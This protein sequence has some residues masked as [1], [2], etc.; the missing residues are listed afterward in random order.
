V[1]VFIDSGCLAYAT[2]SS[3]W[4]RKAGLPCF[5]IPPRYLRVIDGTSESPSI[6]KVAY[7]DALIG[8]HYQERIFA[9]VVPNQGYDIMLGLPWFQDQDV[10]KSP[11]ENRIHIRTSGTRVWN[12]ESENRIL[13]PTSGPG[14]SKPIP[15]SAVSFAWLSRQPDCEVFSASMADIEAMLKPKVKGDPKELLPEWAREYL[16]VFDRILAAKLP[17]HRHDIDHEINLVT[18][19]KGDEVQPPWGPL[20]SMTKDEL[21]VLRKTL[22]ELLDKGFIRVSQSPAAS[23]ILFAKKPGGGLRFCVD[24][25]GLNAVT[26][27][28]R[29]PLPLIKETL[30]ALTRA[31]W[32]TK[33]DIISAF[34][35]VRMK[36]GHEWKTAM[37]TRYGLFEWLVCPFGLTNAPSTFQ[38]FINW[39]LREYLDDF[40]TAYVDDLLIFSSGSRQDHRN[41]VKAVLQKLLDAGLHVDIDKCA[42]ETQEVKYLGFIVEAG[43]GIRMDPEKIRA[44]MDWKYPTSVKGIRS[45]L[46]FANFYRDFIAGFSHIA[47]PLTALTG[48]KAP[49]PF[50]LPEEAKAAFDLLKMKMAEEPV[51]A[52]YNPQLETVL[53]PDS[54][55]FATGGAL[56]QRHPEGLK[57]VA[58]YSKKLNSAEI[59]YPIH[60]KELLAIIRCLEEWNPEL[61]GL[62]QPLT[63]LTDH[64]NLEYFQKK[65]RLTERQVRW[66]DILSQHRYNLKYRPGKEAIVPDALSRRDQ[67]TP[68]RL[69]PRLSSRELQ[70]LPDQI[71][72]FA[73]YIDSSLPLEVSA[74]QI[75][76]SSLPKSSELPT[77][78]DLGLSDQLA[79]LWNQGIQHE[80]A[81]DN[82]TDQQYLRAYQS[83]RTE[84]KKFPNILGLKISM[85]EASLNNQKALCFRSRLWVPNYEPLR[86][87]IMEEIHSSPLSGHPG[88]EVSYKLLARQFFWPNMSIDIRRLIRNCDCQKHSVWRD[89]RGYLKPLPIS[90]RAWSEISWDFITGLP[91]TGPEQA[92]NLFVIVDRLTKGPV[93]IPM[94]DI[95]ALDVAKAFIKYYLPHHIL[96]NTIVSD[97]GTNFVNA[98]WARITEL[99]GITRLLSTAFHPETDGGTE[100]MNQVILAYLRNFISYAQDDWGEWIPVAAAM[101]QIRPASATGLSPFFCTHGYDV[102]LIK[103]T[104]EVAE[105]EESNNPRLQGEAI[106]KKI[107]QATEWAQVSIAA[108]QEVFEKQA[109]KGR[110]EA[111]IYRPGDKVYLSLKNV[112]TDRPSKKLDWRCA[113]YT[114]LE[115]LGPLTYKLDTPP[116]IHNVFH[117]S[118]LRKAASDPFPSQV[119]KDHQPPPISTEEGDLE[120]FVEEVLLAKGPKN[121]R[122]ILV[123]W[124][125]FEKPTWEPIK[126]FKDSVALDRFETT[127]GSIRRQPG[128]LGPSNLIKAEKQR[129]EGG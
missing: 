116:G 31:K 91:P 121:N 78:K 35:T 118:L 98:C 107:Q 68:N 100:R 79:S 129:G 49:I 14:L 90:Q 24:Y 15:V 4:A 57:P 122:K 51:L 101:I 108:A 74:G 50:C 46:G 29:Y 63:I 55:G 22:N 70:V 7:F 10:V 77:G 119:V 28:D 125:G 80:F 110:R 61:R 62:E 65:Q 117:T 3:S 85:A 75:E 5:P 105:V 115:V 40:V 38:R 21:L 56:F 39:V 94:K 23:P 97:R 18:N 109:N 73:G 19:E 86:T 67:D 17:P 41:K 25:R 58:F 103:L 53:E 26:R 44:I 111:D 81:Q 87:K 27:K 124:I 33:L 127:F 60:D 6:R 106:A 96:P 114:V 83:V 112:S 92:T 12:S 76:N 16:P 71:E 2:V 93:L 95:T 11:K 13:N 84:E 8:N 54:S 37:R 69:D 89:K 36:E 47:A 88:N 66:A 99:L 42:F 20:Y 59:N 45:F 9:Y 34:H 32:L 48:K 1:K 82:P 120:Y 126:A 30:R 52:Q 123:K 72:V 102:G 43:K 64:K 128:W 104:E 113:K